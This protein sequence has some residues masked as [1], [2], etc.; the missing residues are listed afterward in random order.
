MPE[1]TFSDRR[2]FER[3]PANLS[4]KILDL[5]LNKE[6][7]AKTLDVSA[8]GLGIVT[9]EKM[10][11]YTSLGLWLQMPNHGQPLYTKGIVIWSKQVEP[12]K[13]RS[14]ISLGKPEFMGLAPILNNPQ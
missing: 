1:K 5:V 8:N 10:S 12:N 4:L 2:M 9:E 13:Y 7:S 11:P 6:I 3:I 14:G